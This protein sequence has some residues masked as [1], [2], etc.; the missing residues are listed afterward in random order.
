MIDEIDGDEG[1]EEK[2]VSSYHSREV[3]VASLR[4]TIRFNSNIQ[5]IKLLAN[6]HT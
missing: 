1:S 5:R 4:I 3:S 2:A 6:V